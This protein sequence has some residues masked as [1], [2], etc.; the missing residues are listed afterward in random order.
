MPSVFRSVRLGRNSSAA[1][2]SDEPAAAARYS[3]D[4][5]PPALPSKSPQPAKSDQDRSA[6]L[7]AGL[8]V[9]E[10]ASHQDA[11]SGDD[12]DQR[13]PAARL[14]GGIFQFAPQMFGALPR[15]QQ[16]RG[17]QEQRRQRI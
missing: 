1:S 4:A 13:P 12:D 8:A 7:A 2:S 3:S 15:H 17:A 16:A 9:E 11:Q 10:P 5:P 14:V 6:T